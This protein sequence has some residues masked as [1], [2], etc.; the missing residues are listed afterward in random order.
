MPWSVKECQNVSIE[1]LTLARRG[2]ILYMVQTR[3]IYVVDFI[4]NELEFFLSLKGRA[5][6]YE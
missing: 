4:L 2:F 5:S 6:F 3:N 1:P